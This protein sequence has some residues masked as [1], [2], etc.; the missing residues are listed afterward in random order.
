[1]RR[2][3]RLILRALFYATP[4]IYSVTDLPD[5]FHFLGLINPLAGIFTM[6]RAAFFPELWQT[7]PVVT[8]VVVSVVVLVIGVWVFRRLERQILKE[9]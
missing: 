5:G 9:L 7:A 4:I 8:S 6:Y 1:M 2:T 3:T